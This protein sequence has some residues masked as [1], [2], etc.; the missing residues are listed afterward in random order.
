MEEVTE[1]QATQGEKQHLP[2]EVFQTLDRR[3][4]EQIL[5][6]MRG[7]I[8]DDLVYHATIQ[9]KQVTNLSYQGVKEAVRQRGNVQIVDMKTEETTDEIRAV[10]KV[11]DFEN[12]IDV[13][14]AATADKNRPFAWTLA[15]NKAE[16]NGFA[17]LIPAKWYA[18]LIDEWL[19][20]KKAISTPR[21]PTR[22]EVTNPPRSPVMVRFL[23]PVP[24][25]LGADLKD[26]GPYHP[27]DVGTLPRANAENLIESGHAIEIVPHDET[28]NVL[29]EESEWSFELKSGNTVYGVIRGK[30]TEGEIIPASPVPSEMGCVQHPLISTLEAKKQKNEDFDYSIDVGDDGSLRRIVLLGVTGD[31]VKEFISPAKWSFEKAFE[32]IA[33]RNA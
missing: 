4:E 2:V 29:G 10:V 25:I 5:A 17:K 23:Q 9:G 31:S 7:E 24:K 19:L 11:H 27:Q 1:A 13:I 12:N 15:I 28:S 14:G 26:Y 33:E 30:G 22:R 32:K 18:V 16:R 21:E 6:E 20:R 8:L 3:D